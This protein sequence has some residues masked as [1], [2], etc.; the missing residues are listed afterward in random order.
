MILIQ[1]LLCCPMKL[2]CRPF[3]M[4]EYRLYL[5]SVLQA[6]DIS[7]LTGFIIADFMGFFKGFSHCRIVSFIF[8]FLCTLYT[9]DCF[10]LLYVTNSLS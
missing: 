6:I 1:K 4:F 9:I 5:S 10:N 3:E 7:N 2:S 8:L